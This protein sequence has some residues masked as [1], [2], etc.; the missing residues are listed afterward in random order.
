M[1][2]FQARGLQPH[3]SVDHRGEGLRLVVEELIECGMNKVSE[4]YRYGS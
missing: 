3:V 4:I 2:L 1:K